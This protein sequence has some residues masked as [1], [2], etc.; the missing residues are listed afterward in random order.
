MSAGTNTDNGNTLG[1]VSTYETSDGV[2]HNA[3]DVWFRADGL[4]ALANRNALI[5][6]V[7]ADTFG[8]DKQNI[9]VPIALDVSLPSS[10][11]EPAWAD[12]LRKADAVPVS[13]DLRFKVSGLAQAIGQF[14]DETVDDLNY[15]GQTAG[16]SVADMSRP[17]LVASNIVHMVGVM[18]QFDADGNP[19]GLTIPSSVM[20]SASM[21]GQRPPDLM[22]DGIL[23][24]GGSGQLG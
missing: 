9:V 3:A 11:V 10:S 5:D 13:T 17:A 22:N 7:I 19:L 2:V 6:D 23:T 1:L 14:S 8:G 18:K 24:T 15:S 21:M 20:Q 16:G 12:N 4:G